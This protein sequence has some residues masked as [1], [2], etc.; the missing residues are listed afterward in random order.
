MRASIST[1]S[2]VHPYVMT[3]VLAGTAVIAH[4]LYSL[5]V[6]PVGAQWL[7]L[8]ALTLLTGSFSIKVPSINAH[9]SV[10]ETFVFASVLLF[11][12]E[13]GTLTVLLECLVIVLWMK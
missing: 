10:S 5:V 7:L 9:I 13:A 6:H 3:A 4:S 11:G 12:P 2:R 1:T 8:A